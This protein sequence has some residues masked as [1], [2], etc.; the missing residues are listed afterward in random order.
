MPSN[1]QYLEV[2]PFLIAAGLDVQHLI[3][4]ASVKGPKVESLVLG[5]IL[6]T[7]YQ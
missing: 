5:D 6:V 7:E 4:L 1:E 2:Q 3:I